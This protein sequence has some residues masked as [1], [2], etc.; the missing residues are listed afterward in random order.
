MRYPALFV[1]AVFIVMTTS[2]GRAQERAA[3]FK[4]NFADVNGVRLH[5]ASVG[6]GPLVLFVHGY[7]SFWYQWK[8]QMLE[9]G[10]DHLAVGVDMRGYNLSSKPQEREHYK[11][12]YLVEDLRQLAEKLAGPTRKFVLVAHDWGGIIAWTFA[13]F[14]PEMLDRLII[15][16]APHPHISER[17]LRENP[18][19]RYASNYHFIDNGYLAPGEQ[20]IDERDTRE[21]ATRRAHAGFVDAAVRSGRYTEADRQMWIDAWSQVGSTTAGLNYYRAN[22]RNPPFNDRHPAATIPHSWSAS[23]VTEG[24]KSTYIRVP[25]LVLWGVKDAAVLTGNLSGL[26]KWVENLSVKLYPDDDHWVMI[27]KGKEIGQDIR[28]F[29]EDR[30]FPRDSVYRRPQ[31]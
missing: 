31:Q 2:S 7:P 29:I 26:E 30:N 4:D 10:R 11:M 24:A 23:E 12:K 13:M 17:E 16:N 3:G 22:H 21:R 8:D 15:I 19:Q 25:T 20:P 28:Q 18:A 6:Q 14:H 5:Y 9:M 27:E 1:V